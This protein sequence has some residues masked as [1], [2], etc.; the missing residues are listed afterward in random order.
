MTTSLN[1]RRKLWKA[2]KRTLKK[3]DE[4]AAADLIQMALNYPGISDE[5]PLAL[6][7][8]ALSD[9]EVDHV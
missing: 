4:T 2:L 3:Y 9:L 5:V 7:S 1:E 6:V 8:L